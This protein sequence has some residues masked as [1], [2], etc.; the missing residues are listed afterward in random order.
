MHIEGTSSNSALISTLQ[1]LTQAEKTNW[2][3]AELPR[4][5]TAGMDAQFPFCASAFVRGRTYSIFQIRKQEYDGERDKFYWY[6][7]TGLAVFNHD[8]VALLE[9]YV[10]P[11]ELDELLEIVRTAVT[12]LPALLN[13]LREDLGEDPD[14]E[15]ASVARSRRPRIK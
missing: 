3:I 5:F 6:T 15:D 12:D 2:S 10:P 4:R 14:E 7:S 11:R 8:N 13:E 9:V 1:R